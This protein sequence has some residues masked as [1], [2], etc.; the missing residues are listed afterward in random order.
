MRIFN[1][2]YSILVYF[3]LYL[4]LVAI[5]VYSLNSSVSFFDGHFSFIWYKKLFFDIEL[6]KTA[7]RSLF[8]GFV[9]SIF[10]TL[11]GLSAAFV[12]YRYSFRGK[13]IVK[14]LIFNLIIL[15][16]IAMAAFFLIFF[17]TFSFSFSFWS[18]FIAHVSFCLPFVFTIVNTKL[19]DIDKHLLESAQDLGA[20]D[21]FILLHVICP[22][23]VSAI[24][25]SL[26]VSFMLSF[27]DVVVS[28]FVTGVDFEILPIKLYSM[29]RLGITPEI[30]ALV[31]CLVA[32]NL[33]VVVVFNYLFRKK[34]IV[35]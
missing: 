11:L 20:S 33:I 32:F 17:K 31:T 14:F 26:F 27:D 6:L 25:A 15:P 12:V 29:V 21:F 4:P 3:L 7:F 24:V 34:N 16:D 10:S 2:C 5:I 19:I 23:L 9:V 35:F 13:N 30:N 8:L 22:I 18:L 1:N 28:Y